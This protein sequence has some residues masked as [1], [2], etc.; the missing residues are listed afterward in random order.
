MRDD[1]DRLLVTRPR[2]GHRY[3]LRGVRRRR[4]ER[5]DPDCAPRHESMG[6]RQRTKYSSEYF[7]P[8]I[9]FLRKQVGRKWDDVYSEIRRTVKPDGVIQQHL[10]VHLADYVAD[11]VFERDGRL[12]SNAWGG[13]I[14]ELRARPW[15]DSFYVCPR[16]GRLRELVWRG[17]PPQPHPA[18]RIVAPDCQLHRIGEVWY[19]IGLVAVPSQAEAIRSAF[20][21]VL[22]VRLGELDP[23]L[24]RRALAHCYGQTDRYGATRRPLSRRE[25]RTLTSLP[26]ADWPRDPSLP[27]STRGIAVR[28]AQS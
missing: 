3:P 5:Y 22:R 17:H 18:I 20:D 21:R 7:S 15:S 13:S 23:E 19:E 8:L 9:R 27:L 25:L 16:T 4:R 11:P 12:Y 2:W 24:R 26:C 28:K 1:M 6:G 10:Y 14:T